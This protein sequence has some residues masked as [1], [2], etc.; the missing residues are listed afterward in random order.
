MHLMHYYTLEIQRH[1]VRVLAY[2]AF[3]ALFAWLSYLKYKYETV[4]MFCAKLF[5]SFA[6]Y[7]LYMCLQSY[8][9][10]YRERYA[11]QKIPITTKVLGILKVHLCVYIFQILSNLCTADSSSYIG[12]PN[13]AY[14][15]E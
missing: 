1:K 6:V 5:E 2:P 4:I 14:I 7:N 11:G 9:K 12:I 10:P 13:G 8:L 3:Y 15:F